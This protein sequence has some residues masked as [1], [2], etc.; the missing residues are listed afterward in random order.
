MDSLPE[1]GHHHGP[2]DTHCITASRQ[3]ECRRLNRTKSWT[4]P[5]RVVI[6]SM[7]VDALIDT[8]G[9]LDAV[10]QAVSRGRLVVLAPHIVRDQ[11]EK[12]KDAA[13]RG[14]LAAAWDAVPVTLVP[15]QGFVLDVSRLGGAELTEAGEVEPL[16][17]GGRGAMEDALIAATACANAQVLARG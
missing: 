13:R 10:Q 11:L 4:T 16:R 9:L 17:T 12:T 3:V 5:V 2:G 1:G 8:P 14:R 15:S 7:M 6:D